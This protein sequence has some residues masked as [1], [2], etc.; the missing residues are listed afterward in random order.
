MNTCNQKEIYV[1]R[2]LHYLPNVFVTQ[3]IT[4]RTTSLLV[5]IFYVH[6]VVIVHQERAM[7]TISDRSVIVF[8]VTK[9][10]LS[11]EM[12]TKCKEYRKR[13]RYRSKGFRNPKTTRRGSACLSLIKLELVSN[14]F[15]TPKILYASRFTPSTPRSP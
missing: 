15:P 7:D 4:T 13:S 2:S 11:G 8:N 9:F 1:F 6:N 12:F 10:L 14:L 3:K 5:L